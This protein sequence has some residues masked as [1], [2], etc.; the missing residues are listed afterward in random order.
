[1]YFCESRHRNEQIDVEYIGV[2]D[3]S[4]RPF[5]LPF[6]AIHTAMANMTLPNHGNHCF[7]WFCLPLVQEKWG[8]NV[9]GNLQCEWILST[10]C[11]CCA[12]REE[13]AHVSLFTHDIKLRLK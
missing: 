8:R 3:S 2:N 9:F 5:K 7:L 1:M 10:S 12:S 13:T 6:G 4:K 11:D